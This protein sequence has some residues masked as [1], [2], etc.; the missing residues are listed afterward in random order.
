MINIIYFLNLMAV[1]RWRGNEVTMRQ[2][3][4]S[5]GTLARP[6]WIPTLARGNQKRKFNDKFESKRYIIEA[7]LLGSAFPNKIWER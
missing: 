5:N 4:D 3:R 7:K 1:T 2:H 6:D